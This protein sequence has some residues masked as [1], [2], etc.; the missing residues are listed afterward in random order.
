VAD[1]EGFVA[2]LNVNQASAEHNRN[3]INGILWR[4]RIGLPWRDGAGE[5]RQLDFD[6]FGA[7]APA[8]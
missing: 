3:I 7:G 2:R 5:I 1:F 6:L 4:L 8:G